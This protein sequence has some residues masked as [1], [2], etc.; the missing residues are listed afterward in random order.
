MTRF[1][2]RAV[3]GAAALFVSTA[4]VAQSGA[5]RY[6][7]T[8]T[9][10]LPDGVEASARERISTETRSERVLLFDENE[11]LTQNAP[12]ESREAPTDLPMEVDGRRAI[13]QTGG[14]P[15][16]EQTHVDLEAEV[17]TETR[18]FLGRT[19][20]ITGERPPLAW[21]LT[22]E[23]GQFLGY[24]CQ[25]AVAD[26][27]S[28][29]VEAWFTPEVPVPAGPGPY[30]G[31]PGLVLVLTDGRRTYE[32]TEVRLGPLDAPI[33]APSGGRAVTREAFDRIVEEKMEEL[34]ASRPRGE[35]GGL[36][37]RRQ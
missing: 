29:T 27:D 7:V 8:T 28:T 11:A 22:G 19:F 33:E 36:I 3:L 9:F 2:T 6:T 15:A 5:V 18:E 26:R 12:S 25:R 31:L 1:L 35:R 16:D 34:E 13:L 20:R 4:A 17:V 24:P 37:I 10:R 21:R 30:G 14:S 23:R 32:A